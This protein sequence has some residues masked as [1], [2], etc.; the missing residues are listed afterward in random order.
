MDNTVYIFGNKFE[1]DFLSGWVKYN[2][3]EAGISQEALAHGICSTSHLSYFES[4]KKRLRGEI[5]EALLKKLKITSIVGVN[6]IGLIR[7]KLHKLMLQVEGFEYETA[8]KTF[9]ELLS[10][11]DFL[12]ISPYNIEFNIY[13][14]MYDILVERKAY[15][16]LKAFIITLDK[17]YVSLSKELQYLYMLI[18]GKLFYDNVNHIEGINRLEKAYKLKDT[19]WINYRLGVA[20]CLNFEHL[21]SIVYLEKAL[22][23]YLITGRYRN[24]LEC[25]SFLGSSYTF[26]KM[27]SQAEAHFNSVLNGS[28][29]FALNK[30]IF[31]IY[32]NL[33]TLYFNMERYKE[34]MAYCQLAMNPPN[35]S[36]TDNK[37][38]KA[39]W[40]SN[41]L[42]ILAAC[43][44]IEVNTALNNLSN[45]NE[46]FDKYLTHAYES[47][48]YYN[49][50]N[51][52]Y[53]N[54][55]HFDELRFY[56]E[57]ANIILPYYKNIGY[58][59]IYKK[60]QL[61]LIKHLEAKR[62][63]KEANN[64]YKSLLS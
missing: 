40:H 18:T 38:L 63:Y 24:S 15:T 48:T 41:E 2:R 47:S 61:L 17:I 62:R 4:G 5:I 54:L 14:L 31:G 22:N 60:V 10:L 25:H 50:L 7:Q 34:S 33:A 29:Y 58:L 12:I 21:K 6:D 53:L 32:T 13:K 8:A 55:F 51:A 16:D 27:Y 28:D 19:P 30:N 1:Y 56:N 3:I 9:N 23:S 49:Y 35:S 36:D 42:P 26:L 43:I 39:A 11:E 44:Y 37:W 20:Y 52:L 46:I 45:C 59:H 57:L 64:I